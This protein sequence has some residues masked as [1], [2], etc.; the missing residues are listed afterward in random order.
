MR[1]WKRSVLVT[2]HLVVILMGYLTVSAQGKIT[3][4][5]TNH[6]G[7]S[8]Y[9]RFGTV[10]PYHF[11]DVPEALNSLKNKHPRLYMTAESQMILKAKMSSEPYS[12]LLDKLVSLADNLVMKGPPS[13]RP[14]TGKEDEQ[15]WQR[16]V[17]NAIP[18]LAMAYCMTG[19]PKYL[20]SAKEFMLV[21]ASYPTW[22][23][24]KLDNTDLATG[25]Q[26]FGIALGY[27]WLYSELDATSRDSIHKCLIL[28][29]ERMFD[30][31]LN[32][33]VWWY[34]NYLQ[35]HQFVNMTGMVAAGLALY[36][37]PDD[38]DGWILLPLETFRKSISFLPPD[39]ANHEGIPYWEYAV[40]YLLKFMDLSKDLLGEDFFTGNSFFSETSNFRLYGMIP[41]DYWSV[42]DS[43]LMSL[44]DSPR[45]DWYG[46]E[47]LLRKLAS[48][49]NDGYAQW[50]AGELDRSGYC[51]PSAFFLNLI[52]LN[53]EVK[54]QPPT[55]LP[56]SKHFD[57]L[58]IVYMRSDWD[59]KESLSL[60]KC[61]PY[62]GHSATSAFNYDPGGG[63]VHPDV[64]AFQ[65][66]SHGDWLISDEGYAFKR[67]IYQNTLVIN[68]TGQ[69]GEGEMWFNPADYIGALYQPRIVYAKTSGEYD[70]FIGDA[71]PAYPNTSKLKYYYRHLLYLKPDCWVVADEVAAES[72]SQFEFYFHSDF[73]FIPDSENHFTAKGTRG[74]LSVSLLKPEKL[75]A[76]TFLQDIDGVNGKVSSHLNVL[77]V[78]IGDKTSDLFITVLESFYT[79][80]NPVIKPSVVST[81]DGDMLVLEY[82][83]Y[84]HRFRVNPGR[85][86]KKAPLFIEV[87][88]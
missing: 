31:L 87:G 84:T 79:G 74:S 52:W 5:N 25:H 82:G 17:G 86:D 80:Q 18:E 41:K 32:D 72:K 66:F 30:L 28:R 63:H 39:G 49:Y 69:I 75:T 24:Q 64:N 77:K 47:Y 8:T 10:S 35:N 48:E 73:P 40:E 13:F 21:S 44:G 29:G 43:R 50:L 20:N 76:K 1:T 45:F 55:E 59:G 57:D 34:N 14:G 65:I 78:S 71:S 33:K 42:S 60:F 46:P 19:N 2:L 38:V 88:K 54:A 3:F 12:A 36:G 22:G 27:D 4:Q 9:L 15:L 58:D 53:P 62:I 7:V 6:P 61:G 81:P 51:S 11:D 23:A 37:G 68:G 16:E 85:I 70:Y 67:T 56:L 83:N 26:L